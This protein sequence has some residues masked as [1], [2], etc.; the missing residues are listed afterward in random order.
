M[1]SLNLTDCT[2]DNTPEFSLCDLTLQGRVLNC[3]DADTNH[4]L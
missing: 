1:N 2:C 3:Y 4:R